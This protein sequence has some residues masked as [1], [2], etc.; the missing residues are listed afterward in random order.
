MGQAGATSTSTNT[1]VTTYSSASGDQN[2]SSFISGASM[3]SG[4][5]K[6]LCLNTVT[7]VFGVQC[8]GPSSSNAVQVAQQATVPLTFLRIFGGSSGY[9]HGESD[10]GHEGRIGRLPSISLLYW[11]PRNP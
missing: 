3:V 4:Y 10:R 2:Y 1:V 11:T 5:P 7:S 6:L 9:Y 8:Y